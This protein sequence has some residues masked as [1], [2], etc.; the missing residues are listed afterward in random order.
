MA[1]P[2]LIAVIVEFAR[3]A[4]LP[5]DLLLS[6]SAGESGL[7]AYAQGGGGAWVGAF[8]GNWAAH[9]QESWTYLGIEGT[10]RIMARM[11]DQWL[12]AFGTAGGGAAW[13]ADP[14]LFLA[15]FW[16]AAQ[17]SEQPTL[18]QCIAAVRAGRRA[19]QEYLAM[20][21]LPTVDKPPMLWFPADPRNY[22]RGRRPGIKREALV[23]H[24]TAG[25][26]TAEQ[27]GAWFG[28]QNQ[29]QGLT[30][31][32][33]FGVDRQGRIS[34]HVSLDD[35]AY[36]HGNVNKPSA[37]L[38]Q[39]NAGLSPNEW[40]IGIEHLD[41]GTPGDV[42]P[43]QL[44]ASARL[45][46]WLFATELLPHAGTTGCAVDREH[47]LGHYQIDSV[48]RARCPSWSEPRFTAYIARVKALLAGPVAPPPPTPAGD[49]EAWRQSAI[50]AWTAV[51]DGAAFVI[52]DAEVKSVEAKRQAQATI[53]AALA[54]LR[55]LGAQV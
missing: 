24:T 18:T 2:Q 7:D 53:D 12:G 36:A 32:T 46:A 54:E 48:D 49:C 11:R 21:T 22:Q 50:R 14:V 25:Q 55:K 35:T 9:G 17:S 51:R 16:P 3:A 28:G 20:P 38:V 34:Q 44:E 39:D 30:G 4:D 27:L 1:D 47:V 37:R 23:I 29:A 8:Q 26:S 33:H 6:L 41:A 40:A 42:T 43:A 19:Y 10:R 13:T 5:P 45:A 15:R 31:A 52:E